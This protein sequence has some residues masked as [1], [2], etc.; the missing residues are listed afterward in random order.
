MQHLA[1]RISKTASARSPN[2][3]LSYTAAQTRSSLQ[4]LARPFRHQ[5]RCYVAH[6]EPAEP[7]SSGTETQ[8]PDDVKEVQEHSTAPFY[9]E[10]GHALFAKRHSRPFPP[11]F[12]SPPSN[13][14]SD[15]LSTHNRSRDKR[16][17]EYEGQMIRGVTNG[18]DA[19]LVSPRLIAANDGVG[20]WAQKERGHAA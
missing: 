2:P 1:L 7:T 18:D 15:P 4:S 8:T 5:Q 14:F 3:L 6:E 17:Q 12:S 16:R 9:F 11:P 19:V 10:A 13:S 20:Q